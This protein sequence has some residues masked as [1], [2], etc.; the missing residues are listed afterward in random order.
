[1]ELERWHLLLLFP[2][3]HMLVHRHLS[4][5]SQ[6]IWMPSSDL[7]RHKAHMRCAYIHAGQIHKKESNN[8][9]KDFVCF[10]SRGGHQI[11]WV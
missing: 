8:I 4:L 7:Y 9:F 5:Q 1:M 2:G 6:G 11:S 10:E 3:T